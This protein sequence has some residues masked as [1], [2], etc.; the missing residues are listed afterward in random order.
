MTEAQAHLHIYALGAVVTRPKGCPHNY[1]W[2]CLVCCCLAEG[3]AAAMQWASGLVFD[4][5]PY[6]AELDA[7]DDTLLEEAV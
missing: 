2:P 4:P 6:D 1:A 3:Y 5:T 7:G